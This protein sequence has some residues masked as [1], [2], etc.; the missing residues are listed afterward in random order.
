M[1]TK[2]TEVSAAARIAKLEMALEAISTLTEVLAGHGL[3]HDLTEKVNM[4]CTSALYTQE[5]A[6]RE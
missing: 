6:D 5:D 2:Y 4:I 1:A 3:S